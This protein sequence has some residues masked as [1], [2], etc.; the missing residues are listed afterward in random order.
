MNKP[1]FKKLLFLLTLAMVAIASFA[2]GIFSAA[3]QNVPFKAVRAVHKQIF[4]KTEPKSQRGAWVWRMARNNVP[5]HELSKQ[6]QEAVDKINALPYLKGYNLA[7]DAKNVTIYDE[8][9]AY[10]GSNFIVSADAPRAYLLD[11]KG[12]TLHEWRKD[13]E[14][15]WPEPFDL[16]GFQEHKEY[17]RPAWPLENGD[18]FAIF[19][20]FGLIKLDK[21]SNLLWSYKGRTHHDLSEAENGNIYVLTREVRKNA[22][23][24]LHSG[25]TK[26]RILE[27]FITI[28]SPEGQEIKKI[29][30]VDCFLNS[31]Y[32]SHLE[33]VNLPYDIFHTNTIKLIDGKLAD[34]HP[35]F[36]K[37][38][39]LLSMRE[40]HTIAVVDPEQGKVTW[41]ITG[42]WKYQHDPRILD[43][44]NMLLFDNRGNNG[45]SKII[46]FNPLTQEVVW[47]YKGDPE[48]AFYSKVG[49]TNQRLPNGNTLMMESTYG[50]AFEVTPAGKIVW[51][52]LN[53]QRAGE[54]NEL[55]ATLYRF[56]RLRPDQTDWLPDSKD[57][58]HT[59]H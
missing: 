59:S 5:N 29:S 20:D 44:G 26:D 39:I 23:L 7:R 27:D 45:K 17:W 47:S 2:Y 52:F 33:H 48:D 36:K 30:L 57:F 22:N 34:T 6:Q 4:S 35:M 51:E 31:V 16:G 37:G 15:V 53:P 49:G 42:M 12:N 50:R 3:Y 55:I 38:H 28:L 24:G 46:E 54:H 9:L 21:N 56:I 58:S 18:L 1:V 41:A 14:D 25:A 11:M 43:N 40:I 8:R 19:P 13:F 10:N 32:A